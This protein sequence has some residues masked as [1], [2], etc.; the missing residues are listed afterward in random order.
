MPT[1]RVVDN[2]VKIGTVGS[3]DVLIENQN[4]HQFWDEL[5]SFHVAVECKH[6]GRALEPTDFNQFK[7]VV[8]GCRM[9]K[10]GILVSMSPFPDT[11]TDYQTKASAQDDVH[12]FGLGRDHLQHLVERSYDVR[13][14][15]LRSVLEVQ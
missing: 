11:F 12:M 10:A 4:R 3:V 14:Q 13:E 5:Q 8:R 9:T 6:R 1:F 15:Y 7:E 2:N